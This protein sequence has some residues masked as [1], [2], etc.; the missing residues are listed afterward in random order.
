MWA[1]PPLTDTVRRRAGRNRWLSHE[2]SHARL[3]SSPPRPVWT[4]TA[5]PREVIRACP[6]RNAAAAALAGGARLRRRG[7][8]D[9]GRDRSFHHHA[10]AQAAARSPPRRNSSPAGAEMSGRACVDPGR[11]FVLQRFIDG[12]RA[13]AEHTRRRSLQ[14]HAKALARGRDSRAC[15]PGE[16]RGDRHPEPPLSVVSSAAITKRAFDAPRRC[17]TAPGRRP[18]SG[19]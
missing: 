17:R 14:P 6:V 19:T 5:R 15:R 2:G 11:S 16:A 3:T 4:I 9:R 7:R 8:Q 12:L 18:R 13:E 1:P 10:G